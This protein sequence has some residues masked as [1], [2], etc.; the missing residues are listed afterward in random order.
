MAP[1]TVQCETRGERA[2]AF[3]CHHL[4]GDDAIG[5]GFNRNEPTED[6]PFPDAWCDECELIRATHDGWNEESEKLTQISLL[7]SDC[8]NRARIRNTRTGV[9]LD[10]LK[11]MRWKCGHYEEWHTGAPLDFGYDAPGYWSPKDQ[12]RTRFLE[13]LPVWLIKPWATFLDDNF[14]SSNSWC[15]PPS[16]FPDC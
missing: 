13:R 8:Y 14:C 3:V 10:D 7:C 12:E 1:K 15:R 5:R 11:E 4:I 9:T 16:S 6:N 2:E